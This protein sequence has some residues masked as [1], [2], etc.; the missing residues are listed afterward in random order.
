M[1]RRLFWLSLLS[2]IVLGCNSPPKKV[3]LFSENS[4]EVTK[5]TRILVLVWD[6]IKEHVSLTTDK[7]LKYK[8]KSGNFEVE[9]GKVRFIKDKN[10]IHAEKSID[11]FQK[12]RWGIR[13]IYKFK[14]LFLL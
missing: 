14:E 4:G 8:N 6:E 5:E 10:V 13:F 3:I 7:K 1:A 9:I 12:K 11:N 2:L